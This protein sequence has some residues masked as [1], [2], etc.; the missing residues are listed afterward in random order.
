MHSRAATWTLKRGR[1][2]QLTEAPEKARKVTAR[3]VK[4]RPAMLTP[5][6]LQK[7]EREIAPHLDQQAPPMYLQRQTWPVGRHKL[8]FLD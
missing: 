2:F 7:H 1:Y 4:R 5:V 3:R 8:W 6:N